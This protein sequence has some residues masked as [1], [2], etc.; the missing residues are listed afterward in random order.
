MALLMGNLFTVDKSS[1]CIDLFYNEVKRSIWN[2]VVATEYSK[3]L[4][5]LEYKQGGQ[6]G[7]NDFAI[8]DSKKC[9]SYN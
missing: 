3:R 9:N 6:P 5:S 7:Q 1:P 2:I 8:L 4:V